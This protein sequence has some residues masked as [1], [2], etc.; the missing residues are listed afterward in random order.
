MEASIDWRVFSQRF[1][2]PQFH[3]NQWFLVVGKKEAREIYDPGIIQSL[4]ILVQMC[5]SIRAK[6]H[7]RDNLTNRNLVLLELRRE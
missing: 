4:T 2:H 6:V 7:P 1:N 5:G 3:G